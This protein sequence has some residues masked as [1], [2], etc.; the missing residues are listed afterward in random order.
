MFFEAAE[1]LKSEVEP[2]GGA[3]VLRPATKGLWHQ[4]AWPQTSV[5][6]CLS[7]CEHFN[8]TEP[9][10]QSQCHL[11]SASQGRPVCFRPWTWQVS[12]PHPP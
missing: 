11:V 1:L 7:S 2:G 10:P 8:S 3:V 4:L 12:V 6:I 5:Y 9:R